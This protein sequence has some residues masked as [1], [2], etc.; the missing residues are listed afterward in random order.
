[1][2]DLTDA[3]FFLT[4]FESTLFPGLPSGIQGHNGFL[5]EQAITATTILAEVKSLLSKYDSTLVY[6]VNI[7]WLW[8]LQTALMITIRSAILLEV[9]WQK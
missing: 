1:L 6:T 9:H 8:D 4:D 3:D 5:A 7:F 2:S